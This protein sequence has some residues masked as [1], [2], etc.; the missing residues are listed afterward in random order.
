MVSGGGT[1][2]TFA[3]FKNARIVR[4]SWLEEDGRRLDCNPYMSGALEARDTLHALAARKEPLSSLTTGHAGGI[5]NGPKFARIW[6]DDARYGVPFL[7]NSDMLSVDL[8]SLPLLQKKYAESRQLSYLKLEE[9]TTLITCSGTIGRMAYVRQDMAGMWSSQHIMK[10]VPNDSLIPPGY[11]YAFL[12]SK[13]GVP[14]VVSGTYGAIIQHIE[15]AHISSLPVPRFAPD[16]EL[17][18][19]KLVDEAAK[20]RASAAF[21]VESIKVEL[22]ER[23]GL[24]E[25][26]FQN[27]RHQRFGFGVA[28]SAIAL[29]G[30]LEATYHDALVQEIERRIGEQSFVKVPEVASVVKPGMFKRIKVDGPEWG[31]GFITGSELFSIEPKP[32]YYVSPKT[33]NISDCVLSPYWIL[34]QAFGQ[35]GGLIGRC[36]MTTPSL[37]NC[38]ATDLQI[39]L[40]FSNP[41]DAGYVC[42][43]LS[44]FAGYRLL[45]RTPIGGSIPHIHPKDIEA[46]CLPWPDEDYRHE[47][48]NRMLAAWELR[49][50]AVILEDEAREKLESL[51]EGDN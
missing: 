23:L 44:T 11:L 31:Y 43:F 24:S 16:H 39:Q 8:S 7:S 17:S 40:R 18:I 48:G 47:I 19:A 45:A 51:I 20:A 25:S 13:F 36:V 12:S 21:E 35:I 46:L 50:R 6:V 15:P 1:G 4:S 49:E 34:I 42:A 5:Y 3:S 14:L 30:R 37:A 2:M 26:S 10:V 38:A 9:G 27:L 22:A 29:S 41:S 32:L 28:A 33:P